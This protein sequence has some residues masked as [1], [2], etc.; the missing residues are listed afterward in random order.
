MSLTEFTPPHSI[1]AEQGILGG[2]M[3]DNQAWDV[4]V[5]EVKAE[6]FFRRDHKL[7]FQCIETLAQ[8]ASPFDVVTVSASLE[9]P[10]QVG[11][12]GY[13]ADL[14]KNTPSVANI[15]SYAQIVSKRAHLRR[16]ISFGYQCSREA[17]EERADPAAVQESIEQQM[18]NMGQGRK[19]SEFVDIN[20]TLLNVIDE[21]DRNFNSGDAVNGVPSGIEDLDQLTGG[22]K[23]TDLIILAARPSM[24]KTSLALNFVDSALRKDPTKTV[25][26]YSLEMPASSLIYRLLAIIGRLD[27]KKL[28]EGKLEDEDWPKLQSAVAHI[29]SYRSRLIID[30]TAG[31]SPSEMRS[32]ARRGA[33]QY[34][35]PALIMIDYL[36]LMEAPGAE[37]RNNEVGVI[38]RGLKALAKEFD[39]PVVALSQLNRSLEQRANKRPMNA[40]LRES[41]SIEQDADVIMFVYRDEVYHPE[42]E[43]KGIAEIIISKQRNGPLGTARTAFIPHQTRFEN[44]SPAYWQGAH[45]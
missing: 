27:L 5:D 23:D 11:G 33:R 17:S 20:E 14:A 6:D 34:G 25:Q 44:L 19:R 26:I 41:G 28:M 32:R 15:K 13:L 22:F 24:G 31:L 3:L 29:Q 40:D 2:L 36:Q 38:T 21:I 30:D 12:L 45:T 7:I 42:T 4:I 37:N 39:C 1:E 8:S 18:F 10:D 43:H 9:H 16:L 35:T